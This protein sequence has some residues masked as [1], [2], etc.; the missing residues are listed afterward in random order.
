MPNDTMNFGVDLLPVTTETYNLGSADKKWNIFGTWSGSTVDVEHGGTGRTSLTANALLTGNG[1]SGILARSIFVENSNSTDAISF[2]L[3]GFDLTSSSTSGVSRAILTARDK[4]DSLLTKVGLYGAVNELYYIY[5][6]TDSYR[7]GNNFRIYPDGS[8]YAYNIRPTS[9][10]ELSTINSKSGTYFFTSSSTFVISDI[11][12]SSL[13]WAGLQIGGTLD[14]WQLI[15]SGNHL[16][17]RQNDSGGDNTAS[18]SSW[19]RMI[20]SSITISGD[21]SATLS[22]NTFTTSI[23]TGVVTNTMLANS[24]ITIADN[25]LSLGDTLT[26]T[27]LR[28][29][30]SLSAALRFI[31]V[32]ASDSAYTPSDGGTGAPTITGVTSYTPIVGDVILDSSNDAEYVCSSVSGTTYTWELLGRD[33]SWALSTHDHDTSYYKLDGSNKGTTLKISTQAAAYTNQI[34]FYNNTTKKGSVGCDNNGVMGVYGASKISLRPVLD[35]AT[36]GLEITTSATYPT[37]SMTLGTSSNKW[38]TVYATTF[39]GNATSSSALKNVNANTGSGNR[40]TSADLTHVNNGGV[41]HFKVADDTNSIVGNILHFHW[42][43]SSAWDSQLLIPHSSSG[44]SMKYRASSAASTWDSWRTL[45]DSSNYS[46]YAATSTHTHGNI[47]NDGKLSTANRLVWTDASSNIYAGDHYIDSTHIAI[48]STSTT[49]KTLYVNG[50]SEFNLNSD[51]SSDKKLLLTGVNAELTV[52]SQGIQSYNKGTTTPHV[53]YLQYAG[54]DLW[55]G[56]STTTNAVRNFYG[57]FEFFTTSGFNYS[58]ISIATTSSTNTDRPI[59]FGGA[60]ASGVPVI[61]NSF[62]FNPATNTLTIDTGTLTATSY[63]G[64]AA[65]ASAISASLAATTKMY[66]LGTSTTITSTAANVS[67]AGDT[68]VYLTTTAGELSA[69]RYSINASG[70]EKVRLE[71]NSTDDSLDFVFI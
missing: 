14:K 38:S 41:Q 53:L 18:W 43:T 57:K 30:L 21:V 12:S 55:I 9:I 22:G 35:A 37:A 50:N 34:Q 36:S 27:D 44:S 68:G 24:S 46:T 67:I 31:G 32:V 28:T 42:D 52:G 2:K 13:D 71:Y 3:N 7:G 47:T 66:L 23:G 64:N 40:P 59:W 19:Y 16:W 25:T 29:S 11:S 69:V 4:N 39:D 62:K 65:S 45:L 17:L 26:A 61:D 56:S 70:T 6:G 8:I 20:D 49:T 15:A 51:S 58:G 5:I 33:G 10:S 1:T 54:S 48:G 63:S 60:G